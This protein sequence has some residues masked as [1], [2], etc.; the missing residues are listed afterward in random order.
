M[1]GQ[2]AVCRGAQASPFAS[3]GFLVTVRNME[4]TLCFLSLP[5]GVAGEVRPWVFQL[6]WERC[7]YGRAVIKTV[8][9]LWVSESVGVLVCCSRVTGGD[10]VQ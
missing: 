1:P 2:H 8:R 9:W 10:M 6:L 5:L 7:P 4:L 3:P